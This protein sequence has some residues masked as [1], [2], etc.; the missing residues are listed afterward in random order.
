MRIFY[1][2]LPPGFA[3]P[4]ICRGR[5]P[6]ALSAAAWSLLARALEREFG[7]YGLPAAAL[8]DSG[9][10]Y[11]PSRPD[12][13]FSL[14][15][16]R[17]A[18]LCAVGGESVGADVQLI[19]PKDAAFAPRLMS[20]RERAD[21]TLGEL[22]CL[23]ESVYKLTGGGDLRRMPFYRE[24]GEIT[25]PVPGVRCRLYAGVP[26]CSAAAAAYSP[27]PER[28]ERIGLGELLKAQP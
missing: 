26:G 13:R 6:G 14:S 23:R 12:I 11:F 7:L 4:F 28:L 22:W 18:V 2:E 3:G 20:A 10:P 17:T 19:T 1:T 27:L 24:G 25:A 5:S 16:T 9:A 8:T 15:H 21:F